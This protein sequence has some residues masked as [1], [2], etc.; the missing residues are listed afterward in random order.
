MKVTDDLIDEEFVEDNILFFPFFIETFIDYITP[1]FF[2]PLLK[3]I[4]EKCG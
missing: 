4:I 3:M 1:P 2:K